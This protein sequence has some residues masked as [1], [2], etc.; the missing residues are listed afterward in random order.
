MKKVEA[1]I[2]RFMLPE[3]KAAVLRAGIEG[4]SVWEV[5]GYINEGHVE[6]YRGMQYV[7]D[8]EAKVKLELIVS[9][10][11]ITSAL[12]II[13]DCVQTVPLGDAKILVSAVEEAIRVRTGERSVGALCGSKQ[14]SA[15]QGAGRLAPP[16]GLPPTGVAA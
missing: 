5:K 13:Q 2:D 1:I 6:Q 9:D 11:Q 15:L 12:D 4:M 16:F 7:V 14:P 8:L 3:I 10:E